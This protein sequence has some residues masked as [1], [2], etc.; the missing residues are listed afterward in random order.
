MGLLNRTIVAVLAVVFLLSLVGGI[1]LY[2]GYQ[3]NLIAESRSPE[4]IKSHHIGYTEVDLTIKQTTTTQIGGNMYSCEYVGE[5]KG[6]P[7]FVIN[8]GNGFIGER[9]KAVEGTTYNS[10]SLEI[11]VE[12][13]T[14]TSLVLWVKSTGS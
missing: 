8:Y 11:I 10:M 2:L 1:S 13:V 9:F 3:S 6:D 14:S 4:Y 12:D 5:Y 7:T